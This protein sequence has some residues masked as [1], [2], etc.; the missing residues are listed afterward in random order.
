MLWDDDEMVPLSDIPKDEL[1]PLDPKLL[2]KYKLFTELMNKML[3]ADCKNVKTPKE[4]LKDQLDQ[5]M[6]KVKELEAYETVIE[7][8][9]EL[10][11]KIEQKEIDAQKKEE[12]KKK[13]DAFQKSVDELDRYE[14]MKELFKTAEQF[15]KEMEAMDDKKAFREHT[16]K[17]IQM[18][19]EMDNTSAAI[20]E[21]RQTGLHPSISS[22]LQAPGTFAPNKTLFQ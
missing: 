6:K 19:E 4:N 2:N 13:I 14:Q 1:Q 15:G 17:I 22:G 18:V 11:R 5:M 8:I 20:N 16:Q 3:T 10:E 9:K 7:Q 12:L 21:I